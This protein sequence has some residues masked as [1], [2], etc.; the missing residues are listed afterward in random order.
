MAYIYYAAITRA[1]RDGRVKRA[2]DMQQSGSA[3][4]DKIAGNGDFSRE[5][6]LCS[7]FN[8]PVD[9]MN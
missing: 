6:L 5:C 4:C 9:C 2:A 3:N 7:K 8:V 1:L